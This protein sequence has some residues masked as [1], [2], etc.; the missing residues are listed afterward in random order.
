[1]AEQPAPIS[2]R[3]RAS[4]IDAELVKFL[5]EKA[6]FAF[7]AN[8][9]NAPILVT[10]EWQVVSHPALVIWLAFTLVLTAA[11]YLLV[12]R[13]RQLSPGPSARGRWEILFSVGALLSGLGWGATAVFFFP[14]GA[15]EHQLFITFVLAGMT[16]GAV[17]TLSPRMVALVLFVIPAL[18]PLGVQ[19]SASNSRMGA[20]MGTM[21]ALFA[22]LM[23]FIA[24]NTSMT[25]RESV[26]LRFENSKMLGSLQEAKDRVEGLN[27][28]LVA[29]GEER[30]QAMEV[31]QRQTE[32]LIKSNTGLERFAP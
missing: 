1:M 20:A 7:L 6:P 24:R 5:Y 4:E 27:A 14:E 10:I 21:V 28:K 19:L 9:I 32:E 18:L 17:T 30:K 11:R 8:V 23:V 3:H 2:S 16:A 26:A 25:L 22:L 31:L 12:R 29:E 15:A 13:F